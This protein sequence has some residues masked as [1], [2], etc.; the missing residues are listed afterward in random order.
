MRWLGILGVL[1]LGVSQPTG[2]QTTIAAQNDNCAKGLKTMANLIEMSVKSVRNVQYASGQCSAKAITFV[3]ARGHM[4]TDVASLM[5]N[6]DGSDDLLAGK[7]AR[8][9]SLTVTGAKVLSASSSDPLWTYLKHATAQDKGRARLLWTY[10]EEDQSLD[11]R[12]AEVAFFDDTKVSVAARFDGVKDSLVR[13]P[14]A[15]VGGLILND[16]SLLVKKGA[17]IRSP[18][19]VAAGFIR[20]NNPR[21]TDAQLKAKGL[22]YIDQKLGRVL[23]GGS[24]QN[25]KALIH[26]MPYVNRNVSLS[27]N[28]FDGFILLRLAGLALKSP[29]E[30]VL[31]GV[32][33]RFGYGQNVSLLGD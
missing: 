8:N 31:N 4:E 16:L 29:P 7:M 17:V 2:A 25:L 27:V 14:M 1:I 22:E 13:N 5:W 23:D 10:E 30:A 26:D 15:S 21:L 33:I 24:A 28:A 19:E 32:D 11:L 18:I 9:M 6:V 20:R 3:D 12:L